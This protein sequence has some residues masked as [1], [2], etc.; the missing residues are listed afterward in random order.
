LAIADFFVT[1]L[2]TLL[3]AAGTDTGLRRGSGCD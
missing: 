1:N 2:Y 3:V